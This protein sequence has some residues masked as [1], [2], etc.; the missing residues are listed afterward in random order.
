MAGEQDLGAV[1]KEAGESGRARGQYALRLAFAIIV[2][3]SLMFGWAYGFGVNSTMPREKSGATLW[4][5]SP[6]M[7]ALVGFCALAPVALG[8]WAERA[9]GRGWR[10]LCDLAS[11]AA[12]ATGAYLC[13][14]L[15]AASFESYTLL[16]PAWAAGFALGASALDALAE[17]A[18]EWARASRRGRPVEIARPAR[19]D[20]PSPY[21][22]RR[23]AGGAAGGPFARVRAAFGRVA[24]ALRWHGRSAGAALGRWRRGPRALLFAALALGALRVLSLTTWARPTPVREIWRYEFVDDDPLHEGYRY[25]ATA[26]GFLASA[27]Y[28]PGHV[29]KLEAAGRKA[30][31]VEGVYAGLLPQ[32]AGER[33]WLINDAAEGPSQRLR[34]GEEG[35]YVRYQLDEIDPASGKHV[36]S[37][38]LE[39]ALQLDTHWHRRGPV[40]VRSNE[41]ELSRIDP[42]TGALVWSSKLLFGIPPIQVRLTPSSVLTYDD[43]GLLTQLGLDD[44]KVQRRLFN[45]VHDVAVEGDT[46]Y[47]LFHD[48]V[49]AYGPGP[50]DPPRWVAPLP[51][52][53]QGLHLAASPGWVAVNA[54]AHPQGGGYDFLVAALRSA[55]GQTVWSRHDAP[56]VY[57]FLGIIALGGDR[58]AYYTSEGAGVIVRD[59]ARGTEH[60]VL[61]LVK[62]EEAS[63]D[64]DNLPP[65]PT[66]PLSLLGPWLFVPEEHKITA[67]RLD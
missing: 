62:G 66:G 36:R 14:R 20:G 2:F 56:G 50:N 37:V 63:T 17:A 54:R 35:R 45:W 25:A 43:N 28:A 52:G 30:W 24:G 32:A 33:I 48:R 15:A 3:G 42:S 21:R 60:R 51:P 29:T 59:L 26:G 27:G 34:P 57:R 7:A 47:V 55:D 53:F 41:K 31:S 58:L 10:L 8:W 5:A 13:T 39:G 44:G 6:A 65:T 46:I 16:A 67:L 11:A 12:G 23:R 61:S 9:K 4:A 49:E 1:A 38:T 22:D 40:L 19:P 64:L 18:A